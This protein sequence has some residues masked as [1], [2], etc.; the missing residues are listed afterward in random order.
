MKILF[1]LLLLVVVLP[2]FAEPISD[3]TGLKTTFSV[4][5]NSKPYDIE[6]T[7]NFDVR[8]VSFKDNTLTFA[9]NSS[10]ENNFAE[11]Q[12]PN[13]ITKGNLKFI[14]DD[15]EITP[16]VLQNEKISFVTL[17]FAGNGTHTLEV[18]SDFVE[19]QETETLE[20]PE[21]LEENPDNIV[22]V[23]AAVGIVV[24]GGAATTAAV[25]FKRKK[26]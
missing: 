22:V 16:K 25:Y 21:I 11:L 6:T 26:A 8:N 9:I 20:T 17:E 4:T 23:L 2:V 13:E 14:L 10:L 5:V 18:Q 15:T 19:Q 7:A 1:A 24:A 12:I 3:R